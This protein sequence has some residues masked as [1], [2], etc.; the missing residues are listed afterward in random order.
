VIK[1]IKKIPE[2]VIIIFPLKRSNYLDP[3]LLK[4]LKS[5]KILISFLLS[6]LSL[7]LCSALP[8]KASNQGWVLY[9]FVRHLGEVT[10][11]VSP[12]GVREEVTRLGVTFV[13]RAQSDE[14]FLY[15]KETKRLC[16]AKNGGNLY[17]LCEAL[18]MEQWGRAFARY[19]KLGKPTQERLADLK[20]SVSKYQISKI[21][22]PN[23]DSPIDCKASLLVDNE[24]VAPSKGIEMVSRL[25]SLP[26]IGKMPLVCSIVVEEDPSK[27][28]RFILR[29]FKRRLGTVPKEDFEPPKGYKM[30]MT[31]YA[32]SER[33][34]ALK[35]LIDSSGTIG[36]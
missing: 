31:A 11:E 12:D 19:E 18:A 21:W 1:R 6:I 3:F 32:V 24:I 15:S 28:R 29:T 26:S 30:V 9:Q 14:T 35:S 5:C 16:S 34:D 25:A 8:S 17:C 2:W 33:E 10:I 7:A 27:E 36:Q 4:A 20:V 22:L 23:R 13:Y